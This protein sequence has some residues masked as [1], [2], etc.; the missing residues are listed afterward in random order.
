MSHPGWV[1]V[2]FLTELLSTTYPANGYGISGHMYGN[3]MLPSCANDTEIIDSLLKDSYNKHYLPNHPVHVR[4]DMWV[5][6]VTAVSELTQDFEIDLY[7]NEFWEDP[8]LIF[9]YMNPCKNNISFDDK[10]LQKLWIPNTCFINSKSAQIHESPFRNVF[11]MVFSNGTLWT[12]YR[13]KLTGPCDMNLK[14]F[15]FDQQKC[16]LTFESFNYNT[17]EVRMNWNQP[18]PVMLLKTIELPDFVLIHFTAE[19]IEQVYP[20]GYWDELTVSFIFK[21]RYGWYILQ[22]YI[23]T[24]VTIFISWISFYLGSRAIPARTMLGVNSLLAMTFQFG[25]IIRNLPRVSYVKAIDVWMLSGMLFIFL[26]LLELAVV[27]FMSRNEGLPKKVKKSKGNYNVEEFSWKEM[28]S[29]QIGLRQFWVEKRHSLKKNCNK[30]DMNMRISELGPVSGQVPGNMIN[31]QDSMTCTV[32][33]IKRD[34]SVSF[35][36]KWLKRI[37]LAFKHLKP[38]TVDKYSAILFPTAYF[39]FNFG[40]WGYYLTDLSSVEEATVA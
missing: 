22:G 11:L 1:M 16:F 27:G 2:S 9:D 33:I 37:K 18:F 35:H 24:Y 12:N 5:Q 7:I 15:P 21:R 39:I 30:D 40:Y 31:M 23:P 20:A 8:A 14:R 36:R 26:S 19:M 32:P 10:V 4:V 3:E 13:M 25:N 29:P 34:H 6:E 38:E 28:P 17:G